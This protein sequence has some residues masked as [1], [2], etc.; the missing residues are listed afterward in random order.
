MKN[1]FYLPLLILTCSL[2]SMD[3]NNNNKK[4]KVDKITHKEPDAKR[5]KKE[6]E[7]KEIEEDLKRVRSYMGTRNFIHKYKIKK[8]NTTRPFIRQH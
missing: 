6:I 2:H 3:N 4:R 1:Y 5:T 7:K 8:R